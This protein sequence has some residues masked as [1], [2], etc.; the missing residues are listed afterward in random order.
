MG[1]VSC[2]ESDAP[3]DQSNWK[4]RNEQYIDSIA[5]VARANADGN[6]KVLLAT[7]L[8]SSKE[9]GNEFY[10]YCHSLQAGS[11]VGSPLFTDYVSVN[12]RGSLIPTAKYPSGYV[13]DGSYDGVLDPSFDVPVVFQLSG[14]VQGFSTAL[15][16]MVRGDVWRVY[17]PW[18]LGY[19]SNEKGNIPSYSALVFDINLVD[20]SFNK[21]D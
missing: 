7:G 16:H 4:E 5:A 9:W 3:S 8:D 15:Q 6:W 14:T 18:M 19:G 13:F 12:Y 1:L 17:I 20:F 2:E 11:G 21:I 10:V